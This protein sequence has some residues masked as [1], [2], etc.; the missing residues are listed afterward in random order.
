VAG[1]LAYLHGRSLVHGDVKARNVVV[2]ADGRAKLADFGCART[3]DSMLPI[4]GTP[5]FMAPEVARGEEQG[6]AADVWA[7]GCTVIEMATGRVPWSDV[8]G[9]VLAAVHQI[10]Y[11]DAVPELPGCLSPEASDFLGKCFARDPCHRSTAAQLL[12]HPFL[13]SASLDVEEE[14]AKHD[15]TMSSPKCTLD[16]EF[17]ESDEEDETEDMRKSATGRIASLASSSLVLPEWDSDDGWID[18]CGK[19]H[20]EASETTAATVIAGAEFGP[21]S[22]A[23]EAEVDAHY[24]DADGGSYLLQHVVAAQDFAG[25]ERCLSV[26]ATGD[27]PLCPIV[28]HRFKIVK[29]VCHCDGERL[30]NFDFEPILFFIDIPFARYLHS[31]SLQG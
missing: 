3:M 24:V 4:G 16:A 31:S 27:K 28:C 1:A 5:A 18:V 29:S 19:Q 11:T 21:W 7:L 8:D 2:G 9:D 12:E 22:E 13:V 14:P 20:S 25:H 6:P 17:W 15:W 10:G 30:I 26:N 23:L